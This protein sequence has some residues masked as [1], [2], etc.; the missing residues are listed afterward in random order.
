M[1]RRHSP[2]QRQRRAEAD[3]GGV[4]PPALAQLLLEGHALHP[5]VVQR[6]TTLVGGEGEGL[7]AGAGEGEAVAQVALAEEAVGSAI[8]IRGVDGVGVDGVDSMG[9]SISIGGGLKREKESREDRERERERY[10]VSGER[11]ALVEICGWLTQLYQPTNND[12][13]TNTHARFEEV[14]RH[15]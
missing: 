7:A 3:A 14:V 8:A 10:L 6:R 4:D 11:I 12:D 13:G 15:P 9:I 5:L 1:E 2:C